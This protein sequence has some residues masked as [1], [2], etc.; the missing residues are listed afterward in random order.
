MIIEKIQI[1]ISWL[2]KEATPADINL[3]VSGKEENN[4]AFE[5]EKT[6]HSNYVLKRSEI[7]IVLCFVY[8]PHKGQSYVYNE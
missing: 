8:E 3:D 4:G 1:N 7:Y 2:F 6:E 5:T